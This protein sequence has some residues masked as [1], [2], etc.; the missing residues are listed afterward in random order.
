LG[1]YAGFEVIFPLYLLQAICEEPEKLVYP[2]QPLHN[3][4]V[5]V[6]VTHLFVS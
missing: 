1:R 5:F 3:V 4:I 2:L 6:F